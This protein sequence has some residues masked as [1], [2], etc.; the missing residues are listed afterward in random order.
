M[1]LAKYCRNRVEI[2][3]GDIDGYWQ[4]DIDGY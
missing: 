2:Y 4:Y 3:L 1:L